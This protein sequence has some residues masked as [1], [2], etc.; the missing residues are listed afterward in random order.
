VSILVE[1]YEEGR[2]MRVLVIAVGTLCA[3]AA[4]VLAEELTA[5]EKT[6]A[7]ACVT[8]LT[9]ASARQRE[10]AAAALAR[11]GPAAVPVVLA[12]VPSFKT[13]EHWA[14]VGDALVGMGAAAALK[15]LEKT[16]KSW[17]TA[18]VA[19]REALIERLEKAAAAPAANGG[20]RGKTP[21]ASPD[22]VAAQVRTILDSF[23]GESMY[24]SEDRRVVDLVRLGR[25]AVSALLEDLTLDRDLGYRSRAAAQALERLLVVDDIP[26][27]A[28]M[29]EDG[30]LSV[31]PALA[32]IPAEV[33]VPALVAPLSKGYNSFALIEELEPFKKDE[34]V[35]SALIHWLEG[36]PDTGGSSLIGST[37]RLLAGANVRPAVPTLIRLLDRGVGSMNRG[38]VALALETLGEKRG[39]E[40]LL[41]VFR[42][43]DT[44]SRH[45]DRH[46]AG[47]RLNRISG[48]RFYRGSSGPDGTDGNFDE[49]ARQFDAWW[50]G[51]K[52]SIRYDEERRTWVTK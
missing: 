43:T 12:A 14:S 45:Y 38:T 51:V 5:A 32:K 8:G 50:T 15:E 3:L 25:P 27:V 47:E 18:N 20:P 41:G 48:Q 13:D 24:S 49:A 36:D 23:D 42:S 10:S 39:I 33:A 52:G 40:E 26:T 1:K 35:T 16:Q 28:R 44:E 22:D 46:A 19:R 37:A 2:A 4:P 9:A 11:L 6:W 17:P 29:L 31:A 34:R 30:H 21:P 7:R